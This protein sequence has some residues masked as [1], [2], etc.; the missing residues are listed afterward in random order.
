M[1]AEGCPHLILVETRILHLEMDISC[2]VRFGSEDQLL[3]S[4]PR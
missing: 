3:A 2:I 4:L 1:G